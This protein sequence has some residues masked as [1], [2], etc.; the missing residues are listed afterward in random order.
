MKIV[1]SKNARGLGAKAM[2]SKPPK[3][4]QPSDREAKK[5]IMAMNYCVLDFPKASQMACA[6]DLIAML[7]VVHGYSLDTVLGGITESY[8]AMVAGEAKR[9]RSNLRLV[10]P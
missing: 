2:G 4:R 1:G 3:Q 8:E 5:A 9:K 7:A 10:K 6:N